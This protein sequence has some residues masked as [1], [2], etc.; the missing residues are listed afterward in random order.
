MIIVNTNEGKII[1]NSYMIEY[2]RIN[3]TGDETYQVMLA[4]PI[5]KFTLEEKYKTWE[6]AK[7]AVLALNPEMEPVTKQYIVNLKR[8]LIAKP[9]KVAGKTIA[10][11]VSFGNYS[12]S[13]AADWLLEDFIKKYPQILELDVIPQ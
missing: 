4:L 5:G 2:A 3:E 13:I 11:T 10:Y 6:E 1:L 9:H 12:I 8:V 7:N